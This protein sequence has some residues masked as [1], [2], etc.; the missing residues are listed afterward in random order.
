MPNIAPGK[1]YLRLNAPEG[2][3]FHLEKLR[4]AAAKVLPEEKANVWCKDDGMF[5]AF[6]IERFWLAHEA[7]AGADAKMREMDEKAAELRKKQ[8]ELKEL[9]EAL[10][11]EYVALLADFK[12]AGGIKEDLLALLR[13]VRSAGMKPAEFVRLMEV[14]N[15]SGTI[16]QTAYLESRLKQRLDETEKMENAISAMQEIVA[17]LVRRKEELEHEVE[18][19]MRDLERADNAVTLACGI[20]RDVGLYVD[21]IRDACAARGAMTVREVMLTPAL[22][23]AGAILEATTSAYGDKEITL[24]PGPRHPLPTQV[25]VR[26]IARSLAPPEAYRAQQEAE[27]RAKAKAEQIIAAGGQ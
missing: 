22:V 25:T 9:L 18:V 20:A 16:A 3:K 5:L 10:N 21:W 19:K 13:L 23:M 14:E 11:Q 24:M 15:V 4:K 1:E 26:E 8:A 2:T 12:K 27:M 7:A 17:Q 6:M